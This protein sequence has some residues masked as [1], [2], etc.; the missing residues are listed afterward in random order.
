MASRRKRE[1]AEFDRF[2]RAVVTLNSGQN[3]YQPLSD[4]VPWA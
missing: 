1:K 3:Q 2:G 4:H